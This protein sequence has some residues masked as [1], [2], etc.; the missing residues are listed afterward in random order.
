MKLS[1]GVSYEVSG[2]I[3]AEQC[4]EEMYVVVEGLDNS[5]KPKRV[6]MITLEMLD[7]AEERD[8]VLHFGVR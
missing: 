6:P 5:C 2:V 7:S 1:T 3:R 4:G 8:G